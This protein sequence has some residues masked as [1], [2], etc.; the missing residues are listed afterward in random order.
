MGTLL[1]REK[2]KNGHTKAWKLENSKQS[3]SWGRSSQA[4]LIS[5]NP[6][7]PAFLGIIEYRNQ[8]W[9]LN[10][11]QPLNGE[12][13][14]E[15]VLDK[16]SKFQIND[17]EV[18]IEYVD[19]K[20]SLLEGLKKLPTVVDLSSALQ[21]ALVTSNDVILLTKIAPANKPLQLAAPNGLIDIGVPKGPDLE[22]L[23]QDQCT[24]Y[25]RLVRKEDLSELNRVQLNA[26]MD[27]D[28]KK[29]LYT[30][31]AVTMMLILAALFIPTHKKSEE[32]QKTMVV[33]APIK[34]VMPKEMRKKAEAKQKA[35]Q[36]IPQRQTAGEEK[37]EAG[38]AKVASMFKSSDVGGRL[39]KL[40]SKVS[41]Q[42][43]RTT[44]V[45]AVKSGVMAG[46]EQ[47]SGRALAALSNVER[48][49]K[50]WGSKTPG[51]SY[52]VST[53]GKNGTGA[54][55]YGTL[56]G[57]SAG[58][59]GVGLVEDESEVTGGLDREEI[60]RYIKSQ[61]GHILQCYERAL[62]AKPDLFGK[63]SVKF[64]IGSS[65]EVTT[66]NIGDTTL[67][68]ATVEGCILSKVAKW[69]FPS[70]QGGTKVMVTYPFLFKSTN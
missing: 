67:K 41:S 9:C 44:N 61:L 36:A 22:I 42:A 23:R 27:P 35:M 56:S 10:L 50:N 25:R 1:I 4:D 8:N 19:S 58:Q 39:S 14:L 53:V 6:E 33:Q 3:F 16:N 68:S 20:E 37:K 65:G 66:Q 52:S 34:V 43:A 30:T 46:S 15:I 51:D 32:L 29:I 7:N 40:L 18:E 70:P 57:G 59:A 11:F 12:K 45:I 13:N 54:A 21:I 47:P 62:S 49:G 38:A 63:V 5:I 17:Q 69:K 64:T 24:I 2:L 48:P 60:A 26:S 55:G 28:S 31:G